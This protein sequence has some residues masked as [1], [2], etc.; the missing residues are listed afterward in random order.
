MERPPLAAGE[1]HR[2]HSRSSLSRC[3][4]PRRKVECIFIVPTLACL[5]LECG[6]RGLEFRL[7][8]VRDFKI[9]HECHPT[10]YISRSSML[11]FFLSFFLSSLFLFYFVLEACIFSLFNLILCDFFRLKC[12]QQFDDE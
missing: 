9:V 10:F 4:R 12:F 8:N 11:F 6:E 1:P 2:V 3:I 5:P 7:T